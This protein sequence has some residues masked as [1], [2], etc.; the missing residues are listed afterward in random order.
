V[1]LVSFRQLRFSA[2]LPNAGLKPDDPPLAPLETC[3]E[4][5]KNEE[6]IRCAESSNAQTDYRG[7]RLEV[8]PEHDG[9]TGAGRS[10]LGCGLGR[11]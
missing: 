2:L 1:I 9:S 5:P 4:F 3:A 11:E 6:W 8:S 7:G 10:V